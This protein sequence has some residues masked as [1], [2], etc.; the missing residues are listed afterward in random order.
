[1][2]VAARCSC[3]RAKGRPTGQGEVVAGDS[4]ATGRG[5]CLR[6]RG[7]VTVCRYVPACPEAGGRCVVASGV[8]DC[9][10]R[11]LPG[12]LDCEVLAVAG[13]R[14]QRCVAVW[15]ALAVAGSVDGMELD[16][17]GCGWFADVGVSNDAAAT[18]GG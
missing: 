8:S 9:G 12:A 18:A 17:P 3:N 10:A 14:V 2:V 16:Y 6:G 5:C 1:M 13:Q 15:E 4:Y 7:G 11:V